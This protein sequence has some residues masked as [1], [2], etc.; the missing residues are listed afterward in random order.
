MAA[1]KPVRIPLGVCWINSEQ[2][3]IE[4]CDGAAEKDFAL[5]IK[6]TN[7]PLVMGRTIW[8]E[9]VIRLNA[10]LLNRKFE[11]FTTL[12]HEIMHVALEGDRSRIN[13]DE[14]L[15]EEILS[16]VDEPLAQALMTSGLVVFNVPSEEVKV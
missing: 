3:A 1:K 10:S 13:M 8:K 7:E 6:G 14:Q 5:K 4:L 15:V 2:W 16:E 9:R 11:L 12:L